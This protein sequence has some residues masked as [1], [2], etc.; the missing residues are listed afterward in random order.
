[1]IDGVLGRWGIDPIQWRA[2]VR[3]LLRI[4]F[5]ISARSANKVERRKVWGLVLGVIFYSMYGVT[6]FIV[7]LNAKDPLLG[8]TVTVL[9]SAFAV[10]LTLLIGE[11]A[12]LL[13]ASDLQILGHRPVSSRTYMA[14]RVTTLLARSFVVAGATT[15]MPAFGYL[16]EHG[17]RQP[18]YSLAL[19]LSTEL[20]G[21]AATFAIVTLYG[22][23]L[24]RVGPE[25]LKQ[26]VAYGQAAAGFIIWGGF[27]LGT[28]K[29]VMRTV[30]GATMTDPV[31]LLLPPAWFASV[32][33][34]V[35]GTFSVLTVGGLLLALASVMG[36][37]WLIRDKLSMSY[38]ERLSRAATLDAGPVV[39]PAKTWLPRVRDEMRAVLLL[40]RAQILHDMKFRLALISLLPTTAV[41]M[42][43]GGW[44]RDPFVRQQGSESIG[45]AQMVVLF[46]PM[47]ARQVIVHSDA[48]KAAWIFHTTPANRAK[49]LV[50]SRNVIT[51]F[52]ILPYLALVAGL[53][54][55][56]FVSTSHA[57]IHTAFMGLLAA[58]ILQF[59]IMLRAQLPFSVPPG[60][61][62]RLAAQLTT[63]LVGGLLG[64]GFY[65][66]LI[67]FVYRETSRIALTASGCLVVIA[68]LEWLTRWRI[69]RQRVEALCFD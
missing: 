20:A 24:E 28:Q 19:L 15:L 12:E 21:V 31:W 33:P 49:L 66:F 32:V 30:A 11:A 52:F 35:A 9:V 69:R 13:S 62:A 29:L 5:P 65:I 2:L 34:L 60:K 41:Y 64:T 3:A 44:P 1:M 36:F 54:A 6:P 10:A 46:L 67:H 14:V 50:A 8:A 16:L 58:M 23:L 22:L 59:D 63:M 27:V 53:F 7:V 37:G 18:Q 17:W 55:Y 48:H 25:R 38:T 42:F 68:S 4:D 26:Y 57:F 45:I 47:L 56:A 40:V 51:A 43:L 61:D 39:I